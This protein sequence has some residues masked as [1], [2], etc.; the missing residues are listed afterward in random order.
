[1]FGFG[2]MEFASLPAFNV[3]LQAAFVYFVYND[4]DMSTIE[5]TQAVPLTV[6]KDGTIRIEGSRVSLDSVVYHYKMGA[7]AEQIAD[8]FPTLRLVDVYAAIT[9]YLGH[10]DAIEEYLHQ[11]EIDSQ[12]AQRLIEGSGLYRDTKGLRER[13]LERAANKDLIKNRL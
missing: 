9:Y 4:S 3:I 5:M 2:R 11:Q 7:T 1:M 8:K 13:L 6:T 10:R 12:E